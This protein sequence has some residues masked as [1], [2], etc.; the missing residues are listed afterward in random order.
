VCQYFFHPFRKN[1]TVHHHN[2]VTFAAADLNICPHADY[3]PLVAS[4]GM[5][6]PHL[7]QIAQFKLLFHEVPRFS[8]HPRSVFSQSERR[9]L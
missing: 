2:P 4:A 5:R 7:D 9:L 3:G 1:K 6:F 8:A